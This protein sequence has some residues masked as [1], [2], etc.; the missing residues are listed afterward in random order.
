[1]AKNS[2]SVKKT[3]VADKKACSAGRSCQP[4]IRC[5]CWH[6][7]RVLTSTVNTSQSCLT[8]DAR[9]WPAWLSAA[10]HSREPNECPSI[11]CAEG[12]VQ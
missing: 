7:S 4:T 10:T 12:M 11:L 8:A 5:M 9:L 1:M 6:L 3:D 2:P